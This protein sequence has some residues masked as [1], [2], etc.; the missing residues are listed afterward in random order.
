M[1]GRTVHVLGASDARAE[2]VL[3]GLTCSGAYVDEATLVAEAFWTQLLARLSVPGAMCF[4]TTNPDGPAHWLKRQVIDRAGPLGY[5]IF[6]FR[7]SDNTHLDPAYV[8]QITAEYTG[9][10]HRRFILGEWVMAEG[11]VYDMWDPTRHVI[12]SA[13][14]PTLD[15][16]LALG[17][18][19]GTT[20]PTR[21]LLLGLGRGPGG[22]RLYLTDEWAPS[23][24][25]DAQLS[26]Q[27]R[28]W[29]AARAPEQRQRPEWIAVDPAAASFKLQLFH[30]GV[31]GVMNATNDVLAGIRTVAS[32]LSTE[33]LV[34]ADSCAKLIEYLPG[35]S[36]NPK[37]T[38]KGEDAPIK[39]DDH[40]CDA[41]RY[42]IHTTRALWRHLVPVA[43]A[44]DEAPG[45]EASP[46]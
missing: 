34:V 36:W 37:A 28:S 16:V 20:N 40:E 17:V 26:T 23:K 41:A 46:V 19:H 27:L 13:E 9:L 6:R 1:F 42:A 39:T 29:L 45:V 24:G 25:T 3:R 33:R 21:G 18:D 12:R 31:P 35:Y 2:A 32:L 4:A 38:A 10:W 22:P 30:D 15:R 43:A 44:G 8:A 11:A 5:K 14:V 7:L